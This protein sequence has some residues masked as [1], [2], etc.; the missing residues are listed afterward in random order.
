MLKINVKKTLGALSLNLNID[1][2]AKGVTAIFGRSGAG[3]SSLINLVAGLVTP[4][5]GSITLNDNVLFD[6]KQKINLSPEKRHIGYVFQEHRLFPHYTVEKNL[7]YG[8]KRFNSSYFLQIVELLGIQH[9]LERFPLSLS[10]GEK[11]RVAIGRALLSNPEILL[12]DEPL[13][14]L[15][16]PKKQELLNYLDQLSSQLEIP[17]LYV[18]HSLDEIIRLADQVILIEQGHIMAFDQ[19]KSIWQHSAFQQWL[20]EQYHLSLLEL[21][22]KLHQIDY[23]MVELSLGTQSLWVSELPRYQLNNR[24]RITINSRDVSITLEKPQNTSIRNVLQGKICQIQQQSQQ[25]NVEVNVEGQKIWAS[26][27]LWA[28]NDLQLSIGQNV[29]LQIKSVS[30]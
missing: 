29:Y 24:V 3:K 17:I 20:P 12:M 18:T 25:V 15:D 16:L 27:S 30:L 13:S 23:Q 7:K 2:P 28:F 4:Q 10:G 6:S 22:I 8:C 11:Q 19:V 21:P 14:A 5:S 1:I 26:I 9:L